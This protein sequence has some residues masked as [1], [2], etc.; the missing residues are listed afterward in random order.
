MMINRASSWNIGQLLRGYT[1]QYPRN[2]IP[3]DLDILKEEVNSLS[4][5]RLLQNIKQNLIKMYNINGKY[6]FWFN[7]DLTKY[8]TK[9]LIYVY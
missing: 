6:L 4:Y 1:M 5:I 7:Q 3:S 9:K 2:L 8:V